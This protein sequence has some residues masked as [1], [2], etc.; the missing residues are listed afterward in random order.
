MTNLRKVACY[1]GHG[2]WGQSDDFLELPL[3]ILW[4]SESA[5]APSL[6]SEQEA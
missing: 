1:M 3:T 2:A 4:L 6:V 5:A